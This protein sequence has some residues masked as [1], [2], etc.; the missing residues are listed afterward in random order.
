MEVFKLITQGNVAPVEELPKRKPRE[1][2][3]QLKDLLKALI[4]SHPDLGAETLKDP[5]ALY[6]KINAMMATKSLPMPEVSDRSIGDWIKN[7]KWG[8]EK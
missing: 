3:M 5:Y 2:S 6:D 8:D 4:A 7:S 1:P